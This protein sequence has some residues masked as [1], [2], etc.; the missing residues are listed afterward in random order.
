MPIVHKITRLFLWI[1]CIVGIIIL[2]YK[3]LNR[4]EKLTFHSVE[5][6]LEN[7]QGFINKV[8]FAQ[9]IVKNFHLLNHLCKTV[10]LLE[11]EKTLLKNPF[12]DKVNLFFDLKG[13]LH[14]SVIEK[15]PVLWV[16][17]LSGEYYFI[18]NMGLKM[19]YF[20]AR[21]NQLI[22]V[23]GNIAE[24]Y[25]G[26][27]DSLLSS[28]LKE[29]FGF[30]KFI[31]TLKPGDTLC[32]SIEINKSNNLSIWVNSLNFPIRMGDTTNLP[33]KWKRLKILISTI[34]PKIGVNTYSAVDLRF[35]NEWIGIQKIIL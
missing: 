8:V 23:N 29:A 3:S 10:N 13:V 31:S 34:I 20:A 5:V 16:S 18:N 30:W 35:E 28:E 24:S 26:G 12:L 2:L 11:M 27:S 21:S 17:N 7:S 19:P 9:Y 14:A 25:K 6:K 4:W 32:K 22:R 15:I 1:F 33:S